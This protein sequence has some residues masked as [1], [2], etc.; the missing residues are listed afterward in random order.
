MRIIQV[1]YGRT[2]SNTH[3]PYT[4][5]RIDLA[6][7]VDEGEDFRAVKLALEAEVCKR[8]G[9]RLGVVKARSRLAKLEAEKA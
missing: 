8:A 4:T 6:A 7:Q 5:E 3:G 2:F 1:S 9:D